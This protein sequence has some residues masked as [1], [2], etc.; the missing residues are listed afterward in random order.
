[1]DELQV[2]Y[3]NDLLIKRANEYEDPRKPLRKVI[4]DKI[5]PV[6]GTVAGLAGSAAKSLA[7]LEYKERPRLIP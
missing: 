5:I 1:M 7:T 2:K 3:I 4:D 6:V